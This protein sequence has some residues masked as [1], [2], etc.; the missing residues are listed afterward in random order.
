M[1]DKIRLA[2]AQISSKRENKKANFSKIEQLT[3]NAKQEKTDLII[4]PEL[5]DRKS[6][7]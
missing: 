1:K 2:L 3:L 5:S 7:V 6:V 4:F